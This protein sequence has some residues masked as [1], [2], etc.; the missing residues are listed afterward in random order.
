LILHFAF[1]NAL[2]ALWRRLGVDVRPLWRAPLKA[3]SLSEFWAKRWNLAFSEMT[4]LALYRP[5]GR[6]FGR[7]SAT[8]AAFVASGLMHELAISV[9]VRA[10]YGGPTLFFLIHGGLVLLER[11]WVAAGVAIDRKPR[12]G[13]LW[14]ICWLV[15]PLPL[16]FHPWFL[17]GCIWPLVGITPA[18][19]YT[20]LNCPP[21]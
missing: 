13:W 15:V 19:A 17:A 1:F 8:V 12:V 5:L 9:P 10:G 4:T 6:V 2:V 16:L 21:R 20:N 18:E 3:R 7:R 11:R 14:C